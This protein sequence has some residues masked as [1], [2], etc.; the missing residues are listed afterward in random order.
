MG[1]EKLKERWRLEG[2]GRQREAEGRKEVLLT[3]GPPL[4]KRY[5]VEEVILF[6]S[7][8]ADK[9]APTSDIDLLVQPLQSA[10]Y[11]N[12]K[13]DIEEVTGYPVDLYTQDDD[14][15]FVSKIRARGEVIFRAEPL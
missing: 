13:R 11:W 3:Y 7:V 15:L 8:L 1:F 14:P 5:R 10:D 4:F 9:S 12:F 6:G 2:E